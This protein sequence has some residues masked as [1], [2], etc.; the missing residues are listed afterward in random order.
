MYTKHL[1]ILEEQMV[2][3]VPWNSVRDIPGFPF[4]HF[5]DLVDAYKNK[6]ILLGV[7]PTNARPLA[8][9]GMSKVKYAILSLSLALPLAVAIGVSIYGIMIG[10][11]WLLFAVPVAIVSSFIS[12]PYAL[13]DK[14]FLPFLLT[15]GCIWLFWADHATIAF[16]IA[17]ALFVFWWTKYVNYALQKATREV[18]IGSELIFLNFFHDKTITVRDRETG[19]DY[20]YDIIEM[21]EKFGLTG[22]SLEE[23]KEEIIERS[24]ARSKA[25]EWP[26]QNN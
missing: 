4:N 3:R 11:Y 24:V 7:S 26:E 16:I 23:L 19:M 2:G 8:Q 25:G 12:S 21:K 14:K 5:D 15:L 13:G 1:P 10:D 6:R 17:S 9:W 22:N 20:R 18:T